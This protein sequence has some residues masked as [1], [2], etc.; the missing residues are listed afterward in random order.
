MQATFGDVW[1]TVNTAFV[2][3]TVKPI[4]W[5]LTIVAKNLLAK[6]ATHPRIFFFGASHLWSAIKRRNRPRI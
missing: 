3:V 4:S 6:T 5:P 2:S 1:V